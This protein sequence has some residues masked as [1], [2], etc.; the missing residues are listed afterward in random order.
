MISN[1]I[2]EVREA[3][4]QIVRELGILSWKQKSTNLSITQ[5]HILIELQKYNYLT[6]SSISKFLK[7]DKSTISRTIKQ[8]S[9]LNL[10]TISPNSFDSREKLICLT[11]RSFKIIQKINDD[12]DNIVKDAL[13]LLNEDDKKVIINGLKKYAKVIKYVNNQAKLNIRKIKREDNKPLEYIIH[14]VRKEFGGNKIYRY[15]LSD[16]N[17]KNM[18]G[19]FSKRKSEFYVVEKD[20]RIVGGAGI[21]PLKGTKDKI[22]ELQKMYLLPEF[23]GIGIGRKLLLLCLNKAKEKGYKKCYIETIKEMS[24][25]CNLYREFGFKRIKKP[26]GNTGFIHND[27][28]FEKEL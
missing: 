13:Q 23:R 25:A 26:L 24:L 4:R 18:Y 19:A 20:N 28:W 21:A 12:A 14:T 10:V 5:C 16:S 15:S 27:V 17:T 7:L 6:I 8:L 22:C 3:S 1:E 9:N 11:N 2:Q